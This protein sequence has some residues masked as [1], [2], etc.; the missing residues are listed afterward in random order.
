MSMILGRCLDDTKSD[1]VEFSNFNILLTDRKMTRFC[2]GSEERTKRVVKSDANFF[3]VTF[4][5]ND[6]YDAVGF[7]AF[8]QF[9]KVDG[10]L[11]Q[12]TVNGD[13]SYD[14]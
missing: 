1:Y 6:V 12:M 7:E 2:G 5:S 3:R 9:R 11:Q 4:K 13:D 14:N 8:Y 10:K